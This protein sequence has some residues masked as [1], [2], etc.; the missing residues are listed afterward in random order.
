[1]GLLY[2]I[3]S[4]ITKDINNLQLTTVL[5]YRNKTATK[6]EYKF[7]DDIKSAILLRY[8]YDFYKEKISCVNTDILETLKL[9]SD[10]IKGGNINSV[11]DFIYK[12][13]ISIERCKAEYSPQYTQIVCQILICENGK[14]SLSRHREDNRFLEKLE[15]PSFHFNIKKNF[16]KIKNVECILRDGEHLY[17]ILDR[18]SNEK[19]FNMLPISPCLHLRKEGVL[20]LSRNEVA[21]Y[22]V[23]YFS[24]I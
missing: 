2:N 16:S 5:D 19:C 13:L 12:N 22:T 8:N 1:M 4:E 10:I 24:N 6:L 20:S 18:E 11:V 21:E 23:K 14:Y 3:N 15:L 9:E 17:F 7:F